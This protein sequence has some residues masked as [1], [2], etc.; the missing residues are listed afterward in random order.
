M[1]KFYLTKDASVVVEA[2]DKKFTFEPVEFFQPTSSWWG[3]Y[4]TDV[5]QE[6]AALTK[7]AEARKIDEISEDDYDIYE[8]KK[9]SARGSGNLINLPS[10]SLPQTVAFSGKPAQVV[11]E[12]GQKSSDGAPSETVADIIAPVEVRKPRRK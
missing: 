8:V 11:E 4:K 2:D 3:T 7:A 1:T 9:K 12:P 10:K 5:E 6:I